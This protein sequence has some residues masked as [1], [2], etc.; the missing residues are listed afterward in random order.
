M[1]HGP[2]LLKQADLA[3]A[4][5]EIGATGLEVI[6]LESL[7]A[8]RNPIVLPPWIDGG[9][10]SGGV[11]IYKAISVQNSSGFKEVE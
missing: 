9:G 4:A 1:R 10:D 3:A 11:A 6:L 7:F 2:R 5:W 8:E